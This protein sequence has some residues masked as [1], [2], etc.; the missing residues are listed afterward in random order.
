MY[1]IHVVH[2]LLS[3]IVKHMC[4]SPPWTHP[5]TPHLTVPVYNYIAQPNAINVPPLKDS[6]VQVASIHC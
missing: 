3:F 4:H 1:C 6:T 2:D 5:T